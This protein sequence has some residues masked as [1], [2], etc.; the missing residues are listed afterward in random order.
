VNAAKI[1]PHFVSIGT[2]PVRL[3]TIYILCI[4]PH[5]LLSLHAEIQLWLH[6]P[7]RLC[8]KIESPKEICFGSEL[9]MLSLYFSLSVLRTQN[10]WIKS[11]YTQWFHIFCFWLCLASLV[12]FG[13]VFLSSGYKVEKM[14]QKNDDDD[15]HIIFPMKEEK[16]F[17]S[18]FDAH[19]YSTRVILAQVRKINFSFKWWSWQ[20]RLV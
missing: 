20:S 18:S 9:K 8:P 2:L 19:F 1:D 14:F 11:N 17:H 5:S 6:S 3:K 10:E 12:E 7:L 16:W 15:D 4:Y 13:W